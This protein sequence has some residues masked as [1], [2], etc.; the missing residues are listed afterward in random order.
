MSRRTEQE[1]DVARARGALDVERARTELGEALDELK[2]GL[3]EVL[4]AARQRMDEKQHEPV[5]AGTDLTP[6][7]AGSLWELTRRMPGVIGNSLSGDHDRVQSA[8]ETLNRLDGRLRGAGVEL[9][10]HLTGYADRLASLRDDPGG[11][12]PRHRR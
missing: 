1:L 6:D 5:A 4:A 12:G 2:A 8:R 11:S 3:D 9:D 10:D 7:V